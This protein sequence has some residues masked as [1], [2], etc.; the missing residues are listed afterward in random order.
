MYATGFAMPDIE[1]QSR[2][3]VEDDGWGC[4]G[5]SKNK[6]NYSTSANANIVNFPSPP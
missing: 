4:E 6:G 5:K 1:A 3:G 2:R